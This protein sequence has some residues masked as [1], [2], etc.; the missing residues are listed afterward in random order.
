VSE[1]SQNVTSFTPL[2]PRTLVRAVL[3][4]I[5]LCYLKGMYLR[6]LFL[7]G[8]I[9]RSMPLNQA[10]P[11]KLW[12]DHRYRKRRATAAGSILNVLHMVQGDGAVSACN[13]ILT[14]KRGGGVRRLLLAAQPG[15]SLQFAQQS[16]PCLSKIR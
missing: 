12:R 9:D 4:N 1:A 2:G 5:A 15:A 16:L 3:W 13:W 14:N 8:C 11:L 6:N 7:Q 10:F